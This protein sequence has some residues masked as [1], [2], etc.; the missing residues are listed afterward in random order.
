MITVILFTEQINLYKY[1][2]LLLLCY[3]IILF[4]IILYYPCG[5]ICA[6]N[7]EKFL[8]DDDYYTQIERFSHLWSS[9]SNAF[10]ISKWK[11]TD[12]PQLVLARPGTI[13]AAYP[14]P[15]EKTI[16]GSVQLQQVAGTRTVPYMLSTIKAKS[17]RGSTSVRCERFD[18]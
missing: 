7:H 12:G 9:F 14:V 18:N 4:Y 15:V 16:L 2:R 17:G 13:P 10:H 8:T 1:E 6:T 3:I 5:Y 11:Y